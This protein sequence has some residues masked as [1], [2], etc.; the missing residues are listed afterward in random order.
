MKK[1][2]LSLFVIA[3][4]YFYALYQNFGGGSSVYTSYGV[5]NVKSQSTNTTTSNNSTGV[6]NSTTDTTTV[7]DKPKIVVTPPP[8]KKGLYTDGSYVGDAVMAYNDN[9]QVEVTISNSKIS[10]IQFIQYPMSGYSG[11]LSRAVL[12]GLVQE[13]IQIQS[14]NVDAIS[15]A[16]APFTTA[17]F[18]DSLASALVQAKS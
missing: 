10:D 4:F 7:V 3:T 16:S 6:K 15:G 9:V 2:F 13:A 1:I 14:A 18:Q 12:P 11:R 17:A 5:I 8:K